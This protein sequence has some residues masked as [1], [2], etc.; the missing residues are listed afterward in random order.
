VSGIYTPDR[1]VTYMEALKREIDS[2]PK[3]ISLETLYIGGGTPTALS[4]ASLEDLITHIFH[5]LNFTES[6]EATI[7]ANPG[8]V[9][10]KKLL[11]LRS[12]GVNRIS[13]GV[14]SFNDDELSFLG[15]I[16]TSEQAEESIN[17]ARAAGFNNIGIDLIYGIPGQTMKSW[18]KTLEMAVSLEPEH[19]ST[20]ELTVEKGTE[21]YKMLYELCQP[22]MS[23]RGASATKQ[24]NYDLKH[25]KIATHPLGARNDKKIISNSSSGK[26]GRILPLDED[27]IIEMYNYTIEYLS[28]EGFKHYEISNFSKTDFQCRHNLNYWD[29]GEYFGVGLGAHSFLN[30]ERFHNTDNLDD[31]MEAISENRS[32]VK[33]SELITDN[34]AVSEAIFLG[35]RKTDGINMESFSRLYNIN[36]LTVFHNEIEELKNSGLIELSSS[37][38]SN[39]SNLKLTSRGVLLSNEVFAKFI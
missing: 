31:Y 16:H 4:T 3:N 1:E 17:L 27:Q 2:I 28:S 20:Y 26:R 12:S 34:R 11:A 30:R 23:L 14:Q 10:S 37:D 5:S 38:C 25:K 8:S 19:I 24:S 15:R 22:T 9:D 32:P 33:S 18:E 6:Y 7:E 29:R 13:M 21:L 35:L 39:E 36:L